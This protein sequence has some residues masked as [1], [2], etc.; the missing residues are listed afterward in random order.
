[1]CLGFVS[2]KISFAFLVSQGRAP[3]RMVRCRRS[4][5]V[6]AS[7]EGGPRPPSEKWPTVQKAVGRWRQEKPSK[8]SPPKPRSVP[9]PEYKPSRAPELAVAD[10][11]DEVK[12]LEAAIE[13]LGGDNVHT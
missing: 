4:L 12:R 13:V 8:S 6:G 3:Q 2:A 1:M 5:R 7:F 11:V 9:P 10:A